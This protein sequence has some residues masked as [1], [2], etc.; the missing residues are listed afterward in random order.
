MR[1]GRKEM[2]IGRK[3]LEEVPFTVPVAIVPSRPETKFPGWLARTVLQGSKQPVPTQPS[4]PRQKFTQD[5]R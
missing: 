3:V 1:R 4:Q 2:R 5:M